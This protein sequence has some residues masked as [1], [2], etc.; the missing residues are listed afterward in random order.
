MYSISIEPNRAKPPDEGP[1]VPARHRA[2][3][4]IAPH[5]ETVCARAARLF[6]ESGYFYSVPF[7]RSKEFY[8]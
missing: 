4:K 5:D 2:Q 6:P 7:S 1:F 8:P 3:I